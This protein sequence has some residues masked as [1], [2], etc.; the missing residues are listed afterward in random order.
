MKRSLLIIVA[1]VVVGAALRVP[2]LFTDFWLDEIWSLNIARSVHSASDVVFSATGRID[3]NHP[4]NTWFMYAL[5]GEVRRWEIYRLPAL[6][7]GIGSVIV[8]ANAMWRRSRIEAITAALL[9]AFSYPLVFYS[10]EARGYAPAV[11]FALLAYDALMRYVDRATW[12][13]A[14]VFNLACVLGFLS[15]LTFVHF[16]LAAMYW[17]VL[18]ARRTQMPLTQQFAW[19]SRLNGPAVLFAVILFRVFVRDMVIGGA[20]ET[21][22]TEVLIRTLSIA[23]GGLDFGIGAIVCAMVTIGLF[24]AVV[25]QLIKSRDD[26]WFFYVLAV[27]VA[28]ALLL[29]Y[30]RVLSIK[31]Q[32]LMPRYF[33]VAIA[34]LLMAIAHLAT[35]VNRRALVIGLS[36]IAIANVVR[37]IQFFKAGRDGAT[38]A[39]G[40]MLRTSNNPTIIVSTDSVFRA[41]PVFEFYQSRIV[42]PDRRFELRDPASSAEW[43]LTMTPSSELS[44]FDWHLERAGE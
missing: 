20:T 34:M 9:I 13:R 42:P 7:C 10:S 36:V 37:T 16:F 19:W 30:N 17:S 21:K 25:A 18:R 15:H 39:I 5:G 14:I 22:P 26:R 27:V 11:F 8:A 12:A 2:G 3:N 6:A 35:R 32:P 33:L 40:Q 29:F 31:P 38:V 43:K 44:G 23:L 24:V 4:L 41:G 1:I 28:P